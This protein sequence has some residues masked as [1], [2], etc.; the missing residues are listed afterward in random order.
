MK[1]PTLL[2]SFVRR[3]SLAALCMFV[4]GIGHSTAFAI[5]IFGTGTWNQRARVLLIAN[6]DKP[7]ASVMLHMNG[8]IC[9]HDLESLQAALLDSSSEA[10]RS[11]V[12]E[13][14]R[15]LGTDS[16]TGKSLK[17]LAD[18]YEANPKT[19]W[20]IE[21]YH[22]SNRHAEHP[23]YFEITIEAS[24]PATD[25]EEVKQVLL[26]KPTDKGKAALRKAFNNDATVVEILKL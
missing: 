26:G 20:T 23:D 19:A 8:K 4:F 24:I 14:I 11:L 16:E 3:A 22:D 6:S 9:S 17:I 25:F 7:V 12:A 15:N 13:A 1:T 21:A 10:N 5:F 2:P 18:A